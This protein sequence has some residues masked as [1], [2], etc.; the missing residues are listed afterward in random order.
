MPK[1]VLALALAASAAAEFPAIASFVPGSDVTEHAAIDVD[2]KEMIDAL[3]AGD[4]V[5]AWAKYSE[6][7]NSRKGDG[8]RTVRGFSKD[9]PDE[10]AY[11][12]QKAYFGDA[13][14]ADNYIRGALWDRLP[15]T[16]SAKE[17]DRPEFFATATLTDESVVQLV[18]KGAVYM[19]TW[20]YSLHELYSAVK[21]CRAGNVDV[22]GGAPHAWDEYWAFYAGGL[23][24]TDGKDSGQLS[25]A[26]ADK[27][28]GN[29][30]TGVGNQDPLPTWR[31]KDDGANSNVNSQLLWMTRAGWENVAAGECDKAEEKIPLMVNQMKVPLVQGTLRYA[32]KS[33]PKGNDETFDSNGKALAELN[34]F[35]NAVIAYVGECDAASAELIATNI[36]IPDTLDP[37]NPD[38]VV[39]DGFAAVK[40][41]FEDNY[42]CMGITCADVGGLLGDSGYVAGMEPCDDGSSVDDAADLIES[43]KKEFEG[44]DDESDGA[45]GVSALAGLAAALAA[46]VAL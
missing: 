23:A 7:G 45:A 6:G 40:K 46:A 5:G 31:D 44:N 12:T 13:M 27:R 33:D 22:A 9:L 30:G 19:N 14:Y 25:Y 28:Q 1:L 3:A 4:W 20:I 17:G 16:S 36:A 41:A 18:K 15:S 24:G 43:L 8:F 21:K 32:W 38:A 29:F 39:P 34:A 37:A 11:Q 2:V 42:E 10:P 35:G 26:L